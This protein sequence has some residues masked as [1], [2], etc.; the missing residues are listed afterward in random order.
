MTP[1]LAAALAAACTRI[2]AALAAL[3]DRP[4]VFQRSARAEHI[5]AVARAAA[6]H[7][8]ASIP[9]PQGLASEAPWVRL[10][11]TYAPDSGALTEACVVVVLCDVKFGSVS[12]SIPVGPDVTPNGVLM[13]WNAS[14][15]LAWDDEVK[16]HRARLDTLSGLLVFPGD[17][18]TP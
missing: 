3:G 6:T 7:L 15:R 11:T 9:S 14:I 1:T 10:H 17:A 4:S 8:D 2:H 13:A 18:A 5:G 16:A 12:A